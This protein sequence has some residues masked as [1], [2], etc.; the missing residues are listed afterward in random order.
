MN[1]LLSLFVLLAQ[2]PSPA[3][4]APGDKLD[5][6][7]LRNGDELVGRVVT[8]L[9]GYV[10]IELEHGA[11]VGVSR[12]MVKEIRHDA[13]AAPARAE[14]VRPADAWFVLHDADGQSVGWLHSSITVAAD[15]R[16]TV[17]E[18][19]EF[20]N[21]R[22]RYQVTD[23]CVATSDGR[24]LRCYFRERVSEPTLRGQMVGGDRA[25]AAERI[26]DER[27][28]EAV[29]DGTT[30]KVSHL[31][32]RGRKDRELPWTQTATFPL[33]ART[34]ARQARTVVGP[35]TMFD[36]AGE[37]LV[38]HCVDGTGARQI[39]IDGERRRVGEV[40][41]TTGGRQNREWVDAD[42]NVLRRELA[43]PSL[44][45]VASSAESARSAVGVTSIPSAVLAERA[46]RFGLWVPSPSW[47]AVADL[48]AGH[49]VLDNPAHG[50][51]IRLSLLDH[52]ESEIAVETAADAVANWLALLDP[53]LA[54]DSRFATR[55]RGRPAVRLL[56]SDRH[57]RERAA[58]DVLPSEHG[59]L[60]I[61]CRAPVAA[62]DELAGDFAFV[63]RTLEL[64]AAL[65][66]PKRQGPLA[67]DRGGRLR[68]PSGPLPVPTPAPRVGELRR[69]NDVRI[70]K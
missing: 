19:Y 59:F 46:G 38:V 12:A 13:V 70:P 3:A 14:S 62:W 55:V 5:V 57:G 36:P 31:D 48:P 6:V 66:N 37:Q 52:L 25:A 41:E 54:I 35:V 45:A 65:L 40:A 22:R 47:T 26:R 17:N 67:N 24:A 1:A 20:V 23:Q 32:G 43:G 68:P 69:R 28:V 15:G 60:V 44:V 2:D 7:V 8:E 33:L 18:E 10:S 63:R 53:E 49:I 61:V 30:L 56:A 9:D 39:M 34:I 58:I 21:G 27:I 16:F 29:V 50:A 64:D 4:A 51:R 11:Q 42:L